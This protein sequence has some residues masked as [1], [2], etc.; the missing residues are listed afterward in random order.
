V[1]N[2]TV[3]G[4]PLVYLE[5]ASNYTVD[6]AGQVIL[7]RCENIRVESLNLSRTY[8]GVELWET[9]NSTISGNKIT[10]NNWIGIFLY[11]SSGNIISGNN[12]TDNYDDGIRLTNSLSNSIFGNNITKNGFG[13]S[14]YSS[15]G[16]SISGNDITR[17]YDDSRLY[18]SSSGIYLYISSNNSISGN[19]VTA[20][21]DYGISLYSSLDNSISENNIANNYDGIYLTGSSNNSV[22]HNNFI[23]NTRQVHFFPSGY[24]NLW[25]YG[26][27]G[28]YWSD[29]SGTDAN[30]DGIGDTPYIIDGNNTDHY[31]LMTPYA[32]PEF[33]SF[34]I[35]P[36]FMIA[37]L[38]A[39]IA[40]RKKKILS[41]RSS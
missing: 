17:N 14:L 32:I 21:N 36:L 34:L 10:A 9:T 33:P 8:A 22:Y 20:N 4:K 2:N 11:S 12:I 13:I 7:V 23:N 15:S 18:Y 24:A 27:G 6:D 29:Y 37:T 25:D 19:N 5:G 30:H 1:E 16:N 38:L 39:V 31:P 40:Y 26:S 3:D 28:N 41:N 35:L